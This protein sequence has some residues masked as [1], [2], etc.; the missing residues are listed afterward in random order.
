MRIAIRMDDITPDMDWKKFLK[1]KELLDSHGIKPLIGVVPENRDNKLHAQDAKEDFWQYVRDLQKSGW[2]IAMHGFNHLYTTKE[3][4]LFPI[5]SKSEFAGH[6]LAK[7]EEMIKR[8]KEI[9]ESNGISTDIFMAPSHSFDKNTLKALKK[10]G[11]GIITDG[12]GTGPYRER[13]MVFYP[14]SLKRSSSLKDTR[15]G[16]VTFVYHAATMDDGDFER[17]EKL[18][19]TDKVVSYDEYRNL[20][21]SKRGPLESLMQYALARGKRA[22]VSMRRR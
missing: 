8:G 17:L 20:E 19:L 16:L 3:G 1:V 22:L 5:G 21:V 6:S 14:I 7:Q 10:N 4:G 15:D 9:L 11:F 13:D 2:M 18:L 12:F